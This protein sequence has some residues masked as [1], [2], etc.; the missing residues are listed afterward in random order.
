M[1]ASALVWLKPLLVLLGGL[2]LFAPLAAVL[3]AAGRRDKGQV[4]LGAFAGAVLAAALWCGLALGLRFLWSPQA[5]AWFML[6]GPW[7]S[8]L[9]A[10]L[11]WRRA[12]GKKPSD[13]PGAA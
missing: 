11:G 5:A 1:H 8:A 10:V 2:L 7:A 6:G 4:L 12:L 13:A 9:G 3:F